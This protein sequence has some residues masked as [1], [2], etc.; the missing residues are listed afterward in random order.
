MSTYEE[1]VRLRQGEPIDPGGFTHL[2]SEGLTEAE[3]NGILHGLPNAEVLA[4]LLSYLWNDGS[5]E[6]L[7]DHELAT[8][9]R[10]DLDGWVAISPES[11]AQVGKLPVE[12]SAE[13]EYINTAL[14][15][16]LHAEFVQTAGDVAFGLLPN[17]P[18]F[19]ALGEA[20]YG[21]A[22]DL[23]LQAALTLLLA[24]HES[25]FAELWSH[26]ANYVVAEET[27][28]VYRER[29]L[30]EP[31]M[32]RVAYLKPPPTGVFPD[33]APSAQSLDN[34]V[35][36]LGADWDD[37]WD[38]DFGLL[39]SA[40]TA[41]D[42]SRVLSVF[43]EAA[44]LVEPNLLRALAADFPRLGPTQIVGLV[45][46]DLQNKLKIP[47]LA[48]HTKLQ[49]LVMSGNY[50][51]AEDW[52]SFERLESERVFD[53]AVGAASSEFAEENFV[54]GSQAGEVFLS[55]VGTIQDDANLGAALAGP[56][57]ESGIDF[58]NYMELWG[59]RCRYTLTESQIVVGQYPD[60]M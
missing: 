52:T 49:T 32:Q 19:F 35:A 46:A 25:P 43:G 11:F 23:H 28:L 20:F 56:A 57:V 38:T 58:T 8:L 40:M 47:Q 14:N 53:A 13:V 27:V 51:L 7:T 26:G 36:L 6:D 60:W 2:F 59:R 16:P 21:L 18:V 39:R 24:G 55:L 9:A 30:A 15:T 17:D 41:V 3:V 44:T 48:N 45:E 42:L 4:N 22:S 34:W 37:F 1:W 29:V 33:G 5:P 12:F 10:R 31:S 54:G 50:H